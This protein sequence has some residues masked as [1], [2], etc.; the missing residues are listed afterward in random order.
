MYW[1]RCAECRRS[2]GPAPWSC[3]SWKRGIGQPLHRDGGIPSYGINGVAIDRDD[4]REHGKNE[5][6]KIDSC[7]AGAEFYYEFL[8][9][10]TAAGTP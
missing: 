5:R 10:L 6:S 4:A 1:I 9:S 7:Y 3:L 8:K 2:C